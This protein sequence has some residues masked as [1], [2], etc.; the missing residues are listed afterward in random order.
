MSGFFT[1][2]KLAVRERFE[3]WQRERFIRQCEKLVGAMNIARDRRQIAFAMLSECIRE[4]SAA[5]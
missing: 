1:F 4:R 2:L 5:R 3:E